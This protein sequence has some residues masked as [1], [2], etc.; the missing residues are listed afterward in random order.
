MSHSKED[1]LSIR[2]LHS[3]A[4]LVILLSALWGR[5]FDLGDGMVKDPFHQGEYFSVFT[6]LM[7]GEVDFVV[8]SLHGALDFLPAWLAM[9]LYSEDNYFIPTYFIY[10]V[11][12]VFSCLL[13]YSIVALLSRQYRYRP[14][15][16]M[17]VA[18]MACKM[19]GYRD[20]FLL[21]SFLLYL[22]GQQTTN[23]YLN[24]VVEI[25][26]GLAIGLGMFWS[27]DRGIVGV[28]AL[29][30][31]SLVLV[32]QNRKYL[33]SMFV[34]LLTLVVLE[35]LSPVSIADFYV[36]NI[37]FLIE[38]SAQ[39]SY[40]WGVR[41]V[42]LS[43]F[44]AAPTMMVLILLAAS[45]RYASKSQVLLGNAAA[46]GVLILLMYKI[47]IN[48][49]DW[50][51]VLMGLWAPLVGFLAV[52]WHGN[53]VPWFENIKKKIVI[54]L[55]FSLST[56]AVIAHDNV[57][58]IYILLAG[59]ILTP[60]VSR[61]RVGS[62]NAVAGVGG[63]GG[64]VRSLS[65]L[66]VAMLFAVLPISYNSYKVMTVGLSGGLDWLAKLQSPPLN[67]TLV[68]SDV[69][70]VVSELERTN[71]GC[72]FDLSNH[73]V[74]NGVSGLPAC[75]Q[76]TYPVYASRYYEPKM[77]EALVKANP[78]VMIYSTTHWSFDIDG[79][80]MY[81]RFP[82]LSAYLQKEYPDEVCKLSYCLRYREKG[83]YSVGADL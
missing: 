58:L 33:T 28:L 45:V 70:W 13:L 22:I 9:G 74:I 46:S 38:T 53:P 73:G 12:G 52:F 3:V 25:S 80:S 78:P 69:Q 34:F 16:L 5:S 17:L 67:E 30:A 65:P 1:D 49:A 82:V 15:I 81:Q 23:R 76:F 47:A 26:L 20:V 56:L 14:V 62:G 50:D 35:L 55:L 40:G 41:P 60:L 32:F 21:L 18:V 48:R 36:E 19:V 2:I 75:T 37:K 83:D 51:H 63:L 79:K 11:I 54:F 6:T 72:V 31:G 27:F 77:L 24:L 66:Q 8:M 29:G 44:L 57:I 43:L 42:L 61:Q 4:L 68:S 39:W 64:L 59:M 71:A 7:S 10:A